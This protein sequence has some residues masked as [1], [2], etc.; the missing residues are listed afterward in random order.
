[1]GTGGGGRD[2]ARGTTDLGLAT[3]VEG[4][5]LDVPAEVPGVGRRN[6]HAVR[7]GAEE[8]RGTGAEVVGAA[9]LRGID[10]RGGEVRLVTAGGLI[11][12]HLRIDLVGLAR[13]ERGGARRLR[14]R[15]VPGE[16]RCWRGLGVWGDRSRW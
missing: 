11:L 12:V 3:R 14:L 1:M 9:A 13:G 4:E 8:G 7:L 2:V 10:G 15:G 5:E 16:L 6:L